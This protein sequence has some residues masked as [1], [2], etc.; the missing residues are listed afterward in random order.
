MIVQDRNDNVPVFQGS[1]FSANI[2]EVSPVFVGQGMGK[3]SGSGAS[4]WGGHE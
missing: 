2:S 3:V 1:E 4:V